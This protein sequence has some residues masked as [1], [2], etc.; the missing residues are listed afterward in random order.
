M[1]ARIVSDGTSFG[2]LVLDENG[3]DLTKSLGI[4]R[5][6]WQV[7]SGDV[8]ARAIFHCE[9]VELDATADVHLT[10]SVATS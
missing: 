3:T 8:P 1:K 6:E 10:Y 2:T 7:G 4:S 5:I 9:L